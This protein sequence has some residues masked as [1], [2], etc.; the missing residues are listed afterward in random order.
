MFQS[1]PDPK[2]GCYLFESLA[3]RDVCRFQ[4]SPDP[5]AGCYRSLRVLMEIPML[6]QS[7][8]DPKAGC[9]HMP[10]RYAVI[11]K[12]FN[13]HPTR[14]PGA[15]ASPLRHPLVLRVSI[16][17]R[18]EGRVLPSSKVTSSTWPVFQSSP[19]PKAGCY[20]PERRLRCVWRCFNPHPT[21]RPGATRCR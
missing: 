19:D 6:F 7:S 20:R 21:R 3:H 11:S 14:R 9:Y 4:S 18:P 12:G 16:L 2:A 17:T 1:S 13:P 15:T 10:F 8:P 5:K